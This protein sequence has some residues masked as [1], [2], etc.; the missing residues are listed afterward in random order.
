MNPNDKVG[1]KRL[2][3][4]AAFL[5]T[6]PKSAFNIGSWVTQ[7]TVAGKSLPGRYG[8]PNDY[9]T[10]KAGITPKDMHTCG[11]TACALGWAATIPSFRRAGLKLVYAERGYGDVWFGKTP[12]DPDDAVSAFDAGAEFFRIPEEVSEHFFS[13]GEY[14][15][16]NEEVTP[17]MVAA[18][19][20]RY[21]KD[22]VGYSKRHNLDEPP[23]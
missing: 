6:I 12:D 15:Q 20:E 2:A 1:L 19:I 21:V 4:L 23:F 18:R 10:I 7:P 13:P 5:R 9:D 14:T 16:D 3:T 8:G 11:T 17:K 22:P